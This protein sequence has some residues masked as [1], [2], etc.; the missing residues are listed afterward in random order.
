MIRRVL[1]AGPDPDRLR[2]S[3]GEKSQKVHRREILATKFPGDVLIGGHGVINALLLCAATEI[4]P[5]RIW[6]FPQANGCVNI[7]RF[8]RRQVVAVESLNYASD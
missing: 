8:E 3:T 2:P 4:S 1:C 5:T 6:E 7:L